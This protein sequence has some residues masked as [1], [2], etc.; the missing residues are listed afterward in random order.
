M[1][2]LGHAWLSPPHAEI[3][4]G[5][6]TADFVG[7]KPPHHW[8]EACVEGWNLHR[9]IDAYTDRHPSFKILKSELFPLVGHY[10]AVLADIW[11]DHILASAWT[12][13]SQNQITLDVFCQQTY[14]DLH[15][16]QSFFPLSFAGVFHRMHRENWLQGYARPNGMRA[17]LE[18][19][20]FRSPGF[21]PIL[22][23]LQGPQ[24]LVELLT[25]TQHPARMAGIQLLQDAQ[26]HFQRTL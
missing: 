10:A 12:D 5:N 6:F 26:S 15:S 13:L 4:V 11:L 23:K 7:S 3:L 1:N 21:K 24:P 9:A 18:G 20:S 14:Q 16:V 19:L 22:E 17:T 25:L 8:T 2:F